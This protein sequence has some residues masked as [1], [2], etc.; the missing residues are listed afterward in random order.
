M[1]THDEL[2][3]RLL[4]SGSSRV[5][6]DGGVIAPQHNER[7]DGT[8]SEGPVQRGDPLFGRIVGSGGIYSTPRRTTAR[9]SRRGRCN[10]ACAEIERSA[11]GQSKPR[12]VER[13][14][15]DCA[16]IRDTIAT[17]SDDAPQSGGLALFGGRP[18][19]G[20]PASARRTVEMSDMQASPETGKRVRAGR[21]ALSRGRGGAE[22]ALARR[23]AIRGVEQLAS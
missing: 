19:D 20:P 15:K 18:G 10:G 23:R 17:G 1:T 9:T 2:G 4:S 16:P 7:W 3:A 21:T 6:A 5:A 8:I 12:V 14:L 11:G 22:V 13:V